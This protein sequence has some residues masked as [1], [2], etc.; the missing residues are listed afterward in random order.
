MEG[1]NLKFILNLAG[2]GLWVQSADVVVY[3]SEFTDWDG[4]VSTQAGFKDG[5]VDKNILLLG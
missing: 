1:A 2:V 4:C 5:V 3:G